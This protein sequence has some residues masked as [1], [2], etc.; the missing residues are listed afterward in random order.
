MYW[1]LKYEMW[2]FVCEGVVC[3][4]WDVERGDVLRAYTERGAIYRY[5]LFWEIMVS[6]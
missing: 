3:M 1:Y 4:E 2:Y 5:D 6:D